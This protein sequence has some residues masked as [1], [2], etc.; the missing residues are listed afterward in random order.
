M[1][2]SLDRVI[3]NYIVKQGKIIMS[4]EDEGNNK[5][6]V[7]DYIKGTINEQPG[8]KGSYLAVS[9]SAN[10][11]TIVSSYENACRPTEIVRILPADTS[12]NF[13]TH[14]NDSAVAALDM[15]KPEVFWT[16]T[17]RGKK[18]RS[19]LVKPAGFD[20]S[21][22]YPLFV[23]MH[24]GPAASWKNDWGYRWNYHLLAAPGNPNRKQ[25]S[26]PRR[27]HLA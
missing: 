18:I 10:A 25:V 4:V 1:A 5:I 16:T 24:G 23:M 12:V 9:S 3:T 11:N 27:K 13:L 7:I 26:A 15:Q 2:P 20:P 8:V 21:K 19:M 6:M 22:K 17:S 14:F